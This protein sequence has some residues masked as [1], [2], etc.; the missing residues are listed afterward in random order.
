MLRR[1]VRRL[2]ALLLEEQTRPASDGVQ[3]VAAMLEGLRELGLAALPW[4]REARM[5]QAR[6]EFVRKLSRPDLPD[7]PAS[8]DTA[9]L[10]SL[11]QWLPAWLAGISRREHLS[12]LPLSQALRE[13]LLPAQRRALETLAPAELVTPSGSSIGIDYLDDNAPCVA[14]RLQAVFGLEATPRIGGGVIPVT[15]KLLSPAQRPVQITRDLAGFW[16]S[17]YAA[18]RKDMRGRYPKHAWPENP[19]EAT[20]TRGAARRGSKRGAP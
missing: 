2:D 16:R 14:V 7:W 1:R 10:E 11:E 13:R 12:R 4:S 20:P 6:M 19:L 3:T 8:D 18:V 5:L 15:F 17:S 9:L